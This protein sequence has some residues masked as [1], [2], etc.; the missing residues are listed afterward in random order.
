MVRSK[1]RMPWDRMGRS[2]SGAVEKDRVAGPCP[3]GMP[4]VVS[5]VNTPMAVATA[6]SGS[7]EQPG[8]GVGLDQLAGLVEVVEDDRGRVD[9]EG[10]VDRGQ[11]LAGVD[12]IRQRGG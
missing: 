6:R 4:P 3:T 1:A 2:T 7:G 10:V 9:P 11:Q 5:P 12:R 8:D